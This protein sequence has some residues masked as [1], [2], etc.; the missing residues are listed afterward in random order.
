MYWSV[1]CNIISSQCGLICYVKHLILVNILMY[2]DVEGGGNYS[3][4]FIDL[5]FTILLSEVL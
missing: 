5:P 2:E 3:Y 1:V 4:S